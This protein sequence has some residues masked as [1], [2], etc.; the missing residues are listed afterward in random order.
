M[1]N[2]IKA[3]NQRTKEFQQ[4]LETF[5]L[6]K[7]DVENK[8]K[9]INTL[10][11]EVERLNQKNITN[12]EFITRLQEKLEESQERSGNLT[13]KFELE[14]ANLK[15]LIDDNNI[16][17]KNLRENESKLKNKIYEA[18][19]IEDRLLSEMQTLKDDKL[20]FESEIKKKDEE[21]I[22][23]KKRVKLARRESQK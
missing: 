6:V 11:L 17:I 13:G 21:I 23:L 19:Q 8:E 14:M 10:V 12:E 15:A 22:D 1:E 3:A 9:R 4:Q 18:E 16:E 2:T 20:R 7:K 5:S